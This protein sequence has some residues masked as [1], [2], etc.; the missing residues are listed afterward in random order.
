MKFILM[1][2][3]ATGF[4]KK[5]LFNDYLWRVDETYFLPVFFLLKKIFNLHLLKK[6]YRPLTD[7]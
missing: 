3:Y 7:E 1:V 4:L 6:K 2:N 5:I